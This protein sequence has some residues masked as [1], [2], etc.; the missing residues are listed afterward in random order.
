MSLSKFFLTFL[1]AWGLGVQASDAVDFESQTLTIALTQEPP[2]LNSAKATD[3]VSG[4]VLG[5]LM[6]GLVRY[7]RRGKVIPGVAERWEMDE[8]TATFWLREDAKWSDGK[9]VTAHDFVFAWQRVV[10]PKTASEYAFILAPIKNAAEINEGK[11]P[12]TQLGAVALDD[13]T[14]QVNLARPT[15]YFVKLTVFSTL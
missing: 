13:R 2:Q 7:D 12:V 4:T 10:D 1:L 15:A 6:Q 9:P 11:L 5:H 8:K 3:Q 14:L